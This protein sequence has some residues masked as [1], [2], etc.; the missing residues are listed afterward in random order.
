MISAK[1]LWGNV[2]SGGKLQV[3]AQN[4]NLDHSCTQEFML[5]MAVIS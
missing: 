3:D 1:F 2:L 5:K 4:S